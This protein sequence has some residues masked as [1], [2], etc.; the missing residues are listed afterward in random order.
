MTDRRYQDNL[1]GILPHASRSLPARLAKKRS[2]GYMCA[3]VF[4]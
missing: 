4:A 1:E 3:P 2:A